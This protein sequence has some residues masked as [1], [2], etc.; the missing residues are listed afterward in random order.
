MASVQNIFHSRVF[1]ASL[2]VSNS[3]LGK[4]MLNYIKFIDFYL[5]PLFGVRWAA[6]IEHAS[7][8]CAII[9]RMYRGS[10][11]FSFW[12]EEEGVEKST[13]ALSR[14]TMSCTVP[15][16]LFGLY[17]WHHL[18]AEA[19]VCRHVRCQPQQLQLRRLRRPHELSGLNAL[20]HGEGESTS[21]LVSTVP[22][23]YMKYICV[24]NTPRSLYKKMGFPR[25]TLPFSFVK[26]ARSK[27]GSV[28]L[29]PFSY[30]WWVL[31]SSK[32]GVNCLWGV[33]R[34]QPAGASHPC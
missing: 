25:Q 33:C 7:K 3:I 2:E 12:V 9:F 6:V 29:C 28:F 34:R 1:L 32:K 31:Y 16:F 24:S 14:L 22:D 27:T 5:F 4:R 26:E 13:L 10:Q 19:A 21:Q 15:Y 20:R 11:L 23:G 8:T 18:G 30:F 17:C